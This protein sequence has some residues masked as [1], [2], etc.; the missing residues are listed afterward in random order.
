M[1]EKH[2]G[3]VVG[4]DGTMDDL[5]QRIGKMSYDQVAIFLKKM[6]LDLRDQAMGDSKRKRH[7]L[8]KKLSEAAIFL[9]QAEKK[10]EEA[11]NI[12]KPFMEN[13]K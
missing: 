5:V 2:P 13:E 7:L 9:D 11:W 4:F 10:M 3:I 6:S 12:C 8:S 1:N